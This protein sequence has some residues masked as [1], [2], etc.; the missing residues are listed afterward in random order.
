MPKCLLIH[1]LINYLSKAKSG[2]IDTKGH[3]ARRN[4]LERKKLLEYKKLRQLF[5]NAVWYLISN[6]WLHNKLNLA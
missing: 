4:K 5:Q 6:Q 1:D 3:G 2:L